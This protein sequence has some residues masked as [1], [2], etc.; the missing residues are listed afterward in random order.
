ML[1]NFVHVLVES[2]VFLF[3]DYE[4]QLY[5]SGMPVS[6]VGSSNRFSRSLVLEEKKIQFEILNESTTI[7]PI[8]RLKSFESFIFRSNFHSLLS[9]E[10]FPVF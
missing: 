9:R 7:Q 2:N 4:D 8:L 3:I 1:I 10:G 5:V 6:V